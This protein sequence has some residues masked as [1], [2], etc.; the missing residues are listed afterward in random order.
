MID[1]QQPYGSTTPPLTV[2]HQRRDLAL[3]VRFTGEIDM[4]TAEAV[5]K[6]L[7]AAHNDVAAPHPVVVDLAG[8][9]FF[10][11]SGVAELIVANQ[12]AID[13]HTPLRIVA[14]SR[15][16]LRPLDITGI[17]PTLAIHPDIP[18]ALAPPTDPPR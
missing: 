9:T 18:T 13:Q 15:V 11:S 6:A 1:P 5:R 17:A 2:E 8:V 4:T 16:V 3:I 14:T 12:R 7:T 10:G